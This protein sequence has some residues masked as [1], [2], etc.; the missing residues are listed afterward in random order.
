METS[1]ISGRSVIHNSEFFD[2]LRTSGINGMLECEVDSQAI[3]VPGTFK[4]RFQPDGFINAAF[5]SSWDHNTTMP[6]VTDNG[7]YGAKLQLRYCRCEG[8]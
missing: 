7:S 4:L 3:R 6:N 8:V 5:D 2:N 1:F